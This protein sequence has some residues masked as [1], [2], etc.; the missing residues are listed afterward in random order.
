M[1]PTPL[2]HPDAHRWL[3]DR[4]I[5]VPPDAA[6]TTTDANQ[7]LCIAQALHDLDLARIASCAYMQLDAYS[8][9]VHQRNTIPQLRDRMLYGWDR[10]A[11]ADA[12]LDAIVTHLTDAASALTAARGTDRWVGWAETV[13]RLDETARTRLAECT[14][15]QAAPAL[16]QLVD[17]IATATPSDH[18]PYE[19]G[20][21][22]AGV[23]ATTAERAV[24]AVLDQLDEVTPASRQLAV[25]M[26]MTVTPAAPLALL[27]GHAPQLTEGRCVVL[28]LPLTAGHDGTAEITA[29]PDP[30]TL[31]LALRLWQDG[32]TATVDLSFA[33]AARTAELLLAPA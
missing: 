24:S 14:T 25:E 2:T 10:P 17:D 1:P 7:V 19:W 18:H 9:L 8:A 4:G 33:D 23:P 28:A 29:D 6:R 31:R 32:T 20:M 30:R 13:R 5:E 15:R 12:T 26:T 27:A 11:W 16:R 21:A 3:A 22:T